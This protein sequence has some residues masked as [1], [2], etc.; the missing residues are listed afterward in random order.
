MQTHVAENTDEVK[1]IAALFP[2]AR[3]YLDVYR[4]H[5][6]LGE[7]SVL[8]HGIWLDAHDRALLHDSGAQIAFCPSSNLFLGSGLF[9]W[10][11]AVDSGH[12]VTMASDVGGGTSLSLL[13]TL[14]EGYKVQALRGTRLS[15]WTALRRAPPHRDG[16][17]PRHE[18]SPRPPG[19]PSR[20]RRSARSR[21]PGPAPRRRSRCTPGCSPGSRWAT[22]AT[23]SPRSW[24]AGRPSGKGHEQLVTRWH[25]ACLEASRAAWPH[26]H[27]HHSSRG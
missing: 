6:L 19:R 21:A 27:P 15:A 14:A 3:S 4:R 9:D 5:G 16:P 26:L 8:A 24:P 12:R 2:E 10:Q 13:R 22:S 17:P 7:R 11:A 20:L 23:S 1:W 25:G 18:P